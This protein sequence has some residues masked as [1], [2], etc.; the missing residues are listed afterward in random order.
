MQARTP[1]AGGGPKEMW[2]IRFL[3]FACALIAAGCASL[4]PG[5]APLARTDVVQLTKSGQAPA[6]II[7]RLKSTQTVLWLSAKDIVELREAGVAIEVLDYLQAAQLAEMRRRSQFDHL[8]YGP[9]Q[10]PFSR[11][12]AFPPTGGRFSGFFAPFCY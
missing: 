7:E 8:L 4:E 9:E 11:C 12:P 1:C 10:T 6:A 3:L 2:L 5:P